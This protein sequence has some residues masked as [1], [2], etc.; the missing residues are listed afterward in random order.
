M[1]EFKEET[2]TVDM[3]KSHFVVENAQ[4]TQGSPSFDAR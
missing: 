1:D 2:V 3:S 4:T